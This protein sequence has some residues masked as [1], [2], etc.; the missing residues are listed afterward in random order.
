MREAKAGLLAEDGIL[1]LVPSEEGG[2]DR[3][4]GL[5]RLK[6]WLAVRGRG[7]SPEAKD[8]GLEAPRGC[9]CWAFRAA[10]SRSPSAERSSRSSR[11][12]RSSS[13]SMRSRRV[14]DVR[15]RGG[16]GS[17]AAGAGR[18]P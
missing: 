1:S 9:S 12:P 7:F 16:R 11:S 14:R 2:L 3:V 15:L 13:G 4:G 18:L 17:R 5:D 8:Y 10:G 6:D